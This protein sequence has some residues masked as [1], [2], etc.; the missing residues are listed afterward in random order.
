VGEPVGLVLLD[1]HPARA[2]GGGGLDAAEAIDH[3]RPDHREA[4]A[5]GEILQVLDVDDGDSVPA[6]AKVAQRGGPAVAVFLLGQ[7][8]G[9]TTYQATTVILFWAVNIMKAVP[10]AFLGAF[11]AETLLANLYLAPVALLGTW[12]GVRAHFWIPERAFFLL[13]YALLIATGTRLIWVAL[14]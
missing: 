8:F 7:G 1:H 4:S 12:A 2:L 9:K 6:M 10:Y 5:D 3:A 11:T 14:T 13:T